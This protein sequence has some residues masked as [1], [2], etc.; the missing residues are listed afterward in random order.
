M[1]PK[2][3]RRT[4]LRLPS[5][6]PDHLPPH[7]LRQSHRVTTGDRCRRRQAIGQSVETAQTKRLDL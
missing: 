2:P 7:R 4:V 6:R 3:S 5:Q 1:H